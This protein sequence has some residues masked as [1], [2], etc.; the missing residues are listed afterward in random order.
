MRKSSA[1]PYINTNAQLPNLIPH[2][3][4]GILLA[5]T[6]NAAR[7]PFLLRPEESQ[8][9]SWLVNP[10]QPKSTLKK[11]KFRKQ[12]KT[13]GLCQTRWKFSTKNPAATSNRSANTVLCLKIASG[14][15]NR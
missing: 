2:S 12:R 9:Q 15:A 6:P 14:G 5:T 11:W 13:S 10:G 3:R 1:S 8:R 4:L 7:S